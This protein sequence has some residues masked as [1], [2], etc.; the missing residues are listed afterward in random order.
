MTSTRVRVTFVI[1]R[2]AGRRC[3]L[4][5]EGMRRVGRRVARPG[6]FAARLGRLCIDFSSPDPISAR[7]WRRARRRSRAERRAPSAITTGRPHTSRIT[8]SSYLV[9]WRQRVRGTIWDE[10]GRCSSYIVPPPT[11]ITIKFANCPP[12]TTPQ[13]LHSLPKS[14]S[15]AAFICPSEVCKAAVAPLLFYSAGARRFAPPPNAACL[16]V[17]EG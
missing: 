14:T 5:Y 8:S 9:R 6:D 13:V 16:V 12:P 1:A 3:G 17:G 2:T 7:R 15:N 11:T 10:E 4:L